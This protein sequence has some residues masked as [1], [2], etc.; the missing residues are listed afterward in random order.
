MAPKG[1]ITRIRLQKGRHLVKRGDMGYLET[2]IQG[3]QGRRSLGT[4]DLQEATRRAAEG[5]EPAVLIP[6]LKP[7][8]Q[9]AGLTLGKALED[10]DDQINDSSG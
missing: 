2:C 1:H 10:Y 9:P 4:G 6:V 3:L 5:G 7:K 8:P